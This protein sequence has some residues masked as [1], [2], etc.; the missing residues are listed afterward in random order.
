V[1]PTWAWTPYEPATERPWDLSLAAH[2]Y[3]RAGFGASWTELQQALARGPK[4]TLDNLLNPS[5]TAKAFNASSDDYETAAARSG[6]ASSFTAW[7]LRRLVGSPDPLG[8][9]LV[10]FWHNHFAITASAVADLP[11]FQRHLQM[12]RGGAKGGF[13]TLFR[14]LIDDPAMFVALG[15]DQNRRSQPNLY[16]A[17]PWL[18]TFTVGAGASSERDVAELARF[19]TGWFVYG[20]KLRFIEREHDGGDKEILGRT[21]QFGRDELV[22]ILT[23]HPATARNLS[24]KLFHWYVSETVSP[25]DALL[26]PLAMRLRQPDGIRSALELLL[27]SNLFFSEHALLHKIKSSVELAVGLARSFETTPPMVPIAR[28]LVNLGQRLD[29]PPTVNG[30]TGGIDWIN[31]ITIASRLKMCR[32]MLDGSGD[33]GNRFDPAPVAER[34]GKPAGPAAAQYWLDVLVQNQ[35]PSATREEILKVSAGSPNAS[36]RLRGIVAAIISQPEYQL[37]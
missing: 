12:L 7:W 19:F 18:E 10:L 5:D 30:W 9:K 2:L 26:E 13:P 33:Y 16:F 20:G 35:L 11:I 36:E 8:E 23:T 17:R 25:S 34:H 28:D 27:R 4:A 21:G 29:E 1:D 22:E 31:S 6:D 24:R 37:S 32:S 3:R 15:G 14:T